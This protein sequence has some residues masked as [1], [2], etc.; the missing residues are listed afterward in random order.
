M[1]TNR[2]LLIA[3]K[4][5]KET[6][7][8]PILEEELGVI[9]IRNEKFDTDTLG[10]FTG[11]I[12]RKIGVVATLRE[13]CLQAAKLHDCDLVVASEGSFGPHPTL[14]FAVADDEFMMFLYLKNNIEIIAREV[15]LKTNFAGETIS[16]ETKLLEFAMK[17][18][19]P[20]HGLIL[21]SSENNPEISYK[22]IQ[23]ESDLLDKFNQLQNKY[24]SVFIETDMRANFNPTR[25]QVIEKLA[26]Q[27]IKKI[28][29]CCPEC[30]TPGFDV[31]E[32][33]A[34]LRCEQCN[35]TTKST[36]SHLYQCKKCHFTLEKK[37]PN[38]K[39]KESA[40]YCDYCNP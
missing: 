26:K 3:T 1:F 2:K 4:H 40:M 30:A 33:V 29:S 18:L 13:K 34:G 25:M 36:L 15:D 28:K 7:I 9:C 20:S 17:V 22:G 6:V 8:A 35:L 5:G 23:S 14:F 27:L 16:N 32:V 38:G 31:T 21:K 11:E 39:E 37:F 12:E 24:T 10:T 19:F